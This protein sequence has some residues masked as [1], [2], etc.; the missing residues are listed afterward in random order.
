MLCNILVSTRVMGANR[1]GQVVAVMFRL[2]CLLLDRDCGGVV[3]SK[4]L[5]F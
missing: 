2:C 3:L 1:E 4:I 5:L